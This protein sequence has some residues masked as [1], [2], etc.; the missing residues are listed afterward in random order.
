[1]HSFD[2]ILKPMKSPAFGA[3][4]ALALTVVTA[5]PLRAQNNS[6]NASP[7]KPRDAGTTPEQKS[8]AEQARKANEWVD[9]LKLDDA[10]KATRV[11]NVV[12]THLKAV[13]DWHNQHPFSTVP[14]GINP[15]T[16]KKLSE[17]DR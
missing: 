3:C 9:S 11:S 15:V 6:T 7:A 1:M 2:P 5:P 17:L 10:A 12:V 13:R 8:D 16:G 4:L 14:A